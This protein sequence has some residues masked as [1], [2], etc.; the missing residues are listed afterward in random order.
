MKLCIWYFPVAY[1]WPHLE[2]TFSNLS[3]LSANF[4]KWSDT[5]KQFVGKLPTNC[6]SVF[7]HFV[8]LA[9]KGLISKRKYLKRFEDVHEKPESRFL[10]GKCYLCNCVVMIAV[11]NQHSKKS[12]PFWSVIKTLAMNI[13]YTKNEVFH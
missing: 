4:T 2:T 12:C 3:P 8:G 1:V 11:E 10:P 6:L 7:D 5:L 9:L 13:H